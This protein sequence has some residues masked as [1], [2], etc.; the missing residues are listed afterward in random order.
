MENELQNMKLATEEQ[1]NDMSY[2]QEKF[3]FFFNPKSIDNQCIG[4][5]SLFLYYK[6]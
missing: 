6:Q 3:L 4:G 2:G 1:A 5:F